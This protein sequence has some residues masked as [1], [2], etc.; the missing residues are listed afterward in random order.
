MSLLTRSDER[1]LMVE[2]DRDLVD[3]LSRPLAQ[4]VADS[5]FRGGRK[6]KSSKLQEHVGKPKIHPKEGIGHSL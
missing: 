5:G 2:L 4:Q 6:R 1:C 3:M